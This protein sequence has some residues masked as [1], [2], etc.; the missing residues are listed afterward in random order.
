MTLE[1]FFEERE[2]GRILW[3]NGA[4]TGTGDYPVTAVG[5]TESSRRNA[6]IKLAGD[7]AEKAYRLMMSDF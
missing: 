2:S 7:S 6:L 5:A 1:L 4:F 3:S